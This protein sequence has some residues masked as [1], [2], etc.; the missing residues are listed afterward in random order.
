MAYAV[1]GWRGRAALE[2][3]SWGCIRLGSLGWWGLGPLMQCS[4][5]QHDLRHGGLVVHGR[6]ATS[7]RVTHTFGAVGNYEQIQKHVRFCGSK[8]GM[9]GSGARGRGNVPGGMG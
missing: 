1:G 4:A 8:R 5:V 7:G 2:E 9:G 3:A 6:R